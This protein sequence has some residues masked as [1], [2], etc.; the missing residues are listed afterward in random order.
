MCRALCISAVA[1]ILAAGSLLDPALAIAGGA[2]QPASSAPKIDCAALPPGIGM[3]RAACEQM[4]Q[5]ASAYSA[6]QS[7]PS[8]SRPGDSAL[9]CGQIKAELQAQSYLPPNR[10]HTADAGAAATEQVAAS[11][12]PESQ[13]EAALAAQTG[14]TLNATGALMGDAT[15]QMQA[16]P[17]IARLVDLADQKHCGGP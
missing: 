11:R 16:N 15:R 7:D 5:A 9:S 1:T 4:N 14:R 13:N 8:A 17:R 2:S 12:N 3:D 10:S 6:A